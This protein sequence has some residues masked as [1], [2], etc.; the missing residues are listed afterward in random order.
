MNSPIQ[1]TF[2]FTSWLTWEVQAKT[3]LKIG[4]TDLQ[5]SFDFHAFEDCKILQKYLKIIVVVI[6]NGAKCD[7]GY[8]SGVTKSMLIDEDAGILVTMSHAVLHKILQVLASN[9]NSHFI[10]SLAIPM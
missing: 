3:K 2:S 4:V 6:P 7:G 1:G 9:T 5:Q 10:D 8:R